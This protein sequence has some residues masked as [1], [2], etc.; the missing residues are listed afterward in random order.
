MKLFLEEYEPPKPE[1]S[2]V[3]EDGA[4]YNKR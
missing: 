1:V 2:D 3:K 4:V